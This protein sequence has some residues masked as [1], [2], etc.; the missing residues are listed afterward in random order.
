MQGSRGRG[1]G[2]VEISVCGGHWHH[3]GICV[4]G[5]G[6]GHSDSDDFKNFFHCIP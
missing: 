2:F 4:R 3:I 6:V 5:W 1:C